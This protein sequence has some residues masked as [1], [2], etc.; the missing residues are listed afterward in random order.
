MKELENF[1][2]PFM[3]LDSSNIATTGNQ[4]IAREDL[5]PLPGFIIPKDTRGII[6][7]TSNL[8]VVENSLLV[9]WQMTTNAWE[10]ILSSFHLLQN[11][12]SK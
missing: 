7:N 3:A 5:I 6:L 8:I 2:W 9:C 4:C 12:V 11:Q 10:V 1:T